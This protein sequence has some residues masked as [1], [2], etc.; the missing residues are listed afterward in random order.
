MQY[1]R[2][3]GCNYNLSNWKVVECPLCPYCAEVDTIEHYLY[4]CSEA[5]IIW[6]VL[7]EISKDVLNLNYSLTVIEILLGIPCAK[8]TPCHIL[9]LLILVGKQCIN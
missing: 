4:Y 7:R 6:K 3:A 9:N 5:R 2:Y 8:N 1:N